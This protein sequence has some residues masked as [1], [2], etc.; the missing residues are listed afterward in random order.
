MRTFFVIVAEI[1]YCFHNG[2]T[3]PKLRAVACTQRFRVLHK[4]WRKTKTRTIGADKSCEMFLR[5]LCDYY[6]KN[7]LETGNQL[8]DIF[9]ALYLSDDNLSYDEIVYAYNIGL[10]TLKRYRKRFNDLA[11]K[12]LPS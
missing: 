5:M 1:F 2:V 10:S 3:L 12:L 8:G 9:Y 7:D 6:T 4:L 11:A